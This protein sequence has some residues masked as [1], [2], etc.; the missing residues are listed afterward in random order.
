MAYLPMTLSENGDFIF[1]Y[2]T[3][4]SGNIV[5]LAIFYTNR[6]VHMACDFNFT[7]KTL[8]WR[9]Y[10]G[11]RQLHKLQKWNLGNDVVMVLQQIANRKWYAAYLIALT[12]MILSVFKAHSLTAAFDSPAIASCW[13]GFSTGDAHILYSITRCF[14]LLHLVFPFCGASSCVLPTHWSPARKL[15]VSAVVWAEPLP[16]F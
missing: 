6:K 3:H 16:H 13:W 11:H 10:Q 8:K 5:F 12:A 7:V 4:N 2:N 15:L 14:S 9:T 1:Y